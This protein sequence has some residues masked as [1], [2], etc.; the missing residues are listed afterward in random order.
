MA[1]LHTSEDVVTEPSGK[2]SSPLVRAVRLAFGEGERL[3]EER[4]QLAA[5]NRRLTGE[6]ARVNEENASLRDAATIWIRLYEKQLERANR[7]SGDLLRRTD[8]RSR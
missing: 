8:S 7:A 2:G 6:L 3:R 4:E 1:L 5:E